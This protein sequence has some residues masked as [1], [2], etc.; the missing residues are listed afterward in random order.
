M[1]Q[2]GWAVIGC[3]GI[4]E[5]IAGE[6][7]KAGCGRIVACW[8]RTEARAEAF[9]AKF[10]AKAYR[11]PEEAITA[12]GVEGVYIATTH[13]QHAHFTKLCLGHGVP[14]L[15][16]KPFTV[17]LKEA[18]EVFELAQKNGVYVAEAMWTWYN[19]HARTVR[20]WVKSGKVGEVKLVT[21]TFGYPM[22]ETCTNLRLTSPELIGG[23][24]MDIGV[25]PVRYMYELFGMPNSI[26]ADGKLLGGVD[27]FE[28]IVMD[29][30]T[31]Q[32]RLTVSIEHALGELLVIEGTEGRIEV[33]DAHKA[34]EGKLVGKYCDEFRFDALLYAT[35]FERVAEEIRSGKKES[36]YCPRRHTLDT[37]RLLDECRR[38]IGVVYPCEQ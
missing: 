38:Q 3:G 5:K 20:E 26:H 16:E 6:L 25:Y 23:A 12:E 2:F 4:A 21:A 29:Y 10:G 1:K 7:E 24:L 32:A 8:N 28:N 33:P 31:F 35:Q 14:V 37:M 13:D 15:C 30:G 11:T 18:E 36:G 9:A 27:T 17:N 22:L 19:D 34:R